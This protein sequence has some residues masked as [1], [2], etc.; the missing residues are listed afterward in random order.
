[1]LISERRDF[2]VSKLVFG[3][4]GDGM[5]YR[6]LDFIRGQ[7]FNDNPVPT[8]QI[9]H[10]AIRLRQ[11]FRPLLGLGIQGILGQRKANRLIGA[12]RIL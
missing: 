3:E 9:I 8:D 2:R 5:K 7:G 4:G 11:A 1:M 10:A 6:V 12:T